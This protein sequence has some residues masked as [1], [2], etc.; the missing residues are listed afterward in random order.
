[1]SNEE[2]EKALDTLGPEKNTHFGRFV[3]DHLR[4]LRKRVD[5]LEDKTKDMLP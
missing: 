2:F 4:D 1:M 3:L 5:E